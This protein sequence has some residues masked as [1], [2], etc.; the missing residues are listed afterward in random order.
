[1]VSHFLVHSLT[2]DP[3]MLQKTVSKTVHEFPRLSF[4]KIQDSRSTFYS[5][6][7]R[8]FRYNSSK[9]HEKPPL[10]VLILDP[11]YPTFRA[12]MKVEHN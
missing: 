5:G 3:A 1:M 11:Q 6:R 9:A 2:S 8:E 7:K 10:F 4:Q 12:I